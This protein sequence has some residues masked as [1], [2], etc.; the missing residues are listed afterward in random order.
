MDSNSIF[1]GKH[2]VCLHYYEVPVL[3]QGILGSILDT[4]I[5]DC[6]CSLSFVAF[7]IFKIWLAVDPF[8]YIE[9]NHEHLTIIT[10]V[11]VLGIITVEYLGLFLM[12]GT[13]SS[14]LVE[15]VA[16]TYINIDQEKIKF[17]S[18]PGLIILNLVGLTFPTGLTHR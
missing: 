3:N 8:S 5:F 7:Q 18:A 17:K 15:A 6:F 13:T 1:C 16:G 10:T 12:Y 14:G 9:Q 2:V 4:S 11:A